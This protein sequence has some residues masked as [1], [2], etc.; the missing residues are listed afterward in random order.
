MLGLVGAGGI[1]FE[2]LTSMRLFQYPEVLT[3]LIFV[4]IIVMVVERSSSY[5]RERMIW[6]ADGSLVGGALSS[7]VAKCRSSGSRLYPDLSQNLPP[8]NTAPNRLL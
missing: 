3:I 7:H 5:I 4:F 6:V 1:G 2:L 8:S